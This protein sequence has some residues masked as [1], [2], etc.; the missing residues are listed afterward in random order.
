MKIGVKRKH[1]MPMV[2]TL[3]TYGSTYLLTAI[4]CF[5]LL[6]SANPCFE[7]D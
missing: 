1:G 6:K 2:I 3:A 7:V 5:L 4:L